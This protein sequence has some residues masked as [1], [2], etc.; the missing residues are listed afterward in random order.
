ME[1]FIILIEEFIFGKFADVFYDGCPRFG[2]AKSSRQAAR[3]LY[4]NLLKIM[5]HNFK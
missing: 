3:L 5:N 4:M 2:M 1:D